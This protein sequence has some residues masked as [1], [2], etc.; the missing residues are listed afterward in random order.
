MAKNFEKFRK[1]IQFKDLIYEIPNQLTPT[2]CR[3]LINKYEENV[4]LQASGTTFIGTDVGIK[5]SE[6]IN[7]S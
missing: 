6:D 1:K 2:F 5:Q 7:I 3:N 4:H